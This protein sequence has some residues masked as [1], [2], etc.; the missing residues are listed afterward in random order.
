MTGLKYALLVIFAFS[1]VNNE[2]SRI[3]AVFPT[4]S[5]SHQVV[6]RP[7]IMELV[8]RGHEVVLIT[9]DP[10]F[11][12][13]QGP[14]NLTEIDVHDVSYEIWRREFLTTTV[15]SGK[16]EDSK[17]QISVVMDVMVKV[18]EKQM[19]VDEV[20]TMLKDKSQKFDLLIFEAY[21]VPLLALSHLFKAPVIQI[22]SLGAMEENLQI[23]GA[24]SHPLLYPTFLHQ[25]VY[26]LSLW[27]KF[28]AL[29]NEYNT[30]KVLNR[31]TQGCDEVLSRI[32]GVEIPPLQELK[33]NVDMLFLNT[34]PAWERNRPVP[35][36]VLFVGGLHTKPEKELPK[37]LKTYLDSSKH[38]VIYISFGTNVEPALLPPHKIQAIINAVSKTPYDVLWKWNQDE[39]P[40]R[41][42]N[43]KISKWLPQSDLL[44]HP[45]IK[46]FITQGG[47]QSTDEAILAG[48]PL[49]G[50]PMLG[51]QW[52]NVEHYVF[53]KIGIKI[54]M[55]TIS[56]EKISKAIHTIT[57][58][59]SYRQNV[60]RLRT[61]M[62][63]QPQSSLERAVWW[64]EY[65]IR[66]SGAR[67][68]RAPAANM[69]WHQY[70]EL[71]L[72]SYVVLGLL[73]VI[74]LAIIVLSHLYKFVQKQAAFRIKVKG[75]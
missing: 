37:D 59:D 58:D 48:V 63:D 43:I 66:H 25:K 60:V 44:R 53:H 26:D 72:V 22:S 70:L 28:A 20:Q 40:G 35:P 69:P 9:T 27:D 65:V 75:S 12:N 6:F 33:N 74:T 49:I 61:L 54:D 3:L 4:P 32:F 24:V 47:L 52:F 45:K 67:H 7:L 14:A 50:M 41:T 56:E 30:N 42:S 71:E 8:K 15:T 23:V 19:L 13:E 55:D 16:K 21:F 68:L 10:V 34:Y 31:F 57:K 73:S 39:L 36:N 62:Y 46:L 11:K 5:I 2:G 18:L 38:G 29:Y 17:G 1:I 51:D 64:T